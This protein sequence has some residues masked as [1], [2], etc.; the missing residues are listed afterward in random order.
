MQD[1]NSLI[2]SG[3]DRLALQTSK[4][5]MVEVVSSIP[6]G[7]LNFITLLKL[8]RHLDVDLH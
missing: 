5:L 4:S 1:L 2:P 3:H 8:L 6:T 7:G